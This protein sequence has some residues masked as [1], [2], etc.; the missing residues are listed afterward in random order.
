[1]IH[2]A[3]FWSVQTPKTTSRFYASVCLEVAFLRKMGCIYQNLILSHRFVISV[4]TRKTSSKMP[5]K[6]SVT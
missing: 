6:E 3:N 1:M 2:L 5:Y 4:L